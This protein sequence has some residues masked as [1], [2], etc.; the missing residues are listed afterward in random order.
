MSKVRE[1]ET[2]EEYIER[3]WSGIEID[4][5]TTEHESLLPEELQDMSLFEQRGMDLVYTGPPIKT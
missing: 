5:W 4:E 2:R 1:G 3:N